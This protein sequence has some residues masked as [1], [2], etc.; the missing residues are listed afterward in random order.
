MQTPR[1]TYYYLLHKPPGYK[2]KGGGQRLEGLGT[3]WKSGAKHHKLNYNVKFMLLIKYLT[4]MYYLYYLFREAKN[5][6][7]SV[8]DST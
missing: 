4:D 6:T 3:E 1:T 2:S 8:D 5:S 7:G